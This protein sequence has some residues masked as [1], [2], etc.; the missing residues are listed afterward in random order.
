MMIIPTL[1]IIPLVQVIT[2]RYK[3]LTYNDVILIWPFLKEDIN[4]IVTEEKR[5]LPSLAYVDTRFAYRDAETA[6][7]A[8]NAFYEEVVEQKNDPSWVK[9]FIHFCRRLYIVSGIVEDD[10]NF[11]KKIIE[12][13]E[14]ATYMERNK[15]E[16]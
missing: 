8:L 5:I 15:D 10:K 11:D 2:V 16:V 14:L 6:I 13:K 4:V 7:S 12:M 9:S 3:K 1:V